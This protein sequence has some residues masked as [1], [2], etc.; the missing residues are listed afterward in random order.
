MAA[1]LVWFWVKR[2]YFAEGRH[3]VE[4]ALRWGST[5][6]DSVSVNLLLGAWNLAYWMGDYASAESAGQKA[7]ALSREA[8]DRWRAAFSL[9][10]L[11][12]NATTRGEYQQATAL[13]DECL[14][15]ARGTGDGWLI[16]H[17]LLVLGV[18]AYALE[19]DVQATTLF[20]E[21]LALGRQV[22][23][24]WL[25][26]IVA[27]SLAEAF[28]RQDNCAQARSLYVEALAIGRELEDRILIS[29]SLEGLAAMTRAQGQ[30]VTAA[31]LYGAAEAQREAIGIPVE[32]AGR[33]AYERGVARPR[34]A[35]GE[36]AFA[37]A[38]ADGRTLTIEHVIA[39]VLEEPGAGL[40]VR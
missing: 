13:A 28:Q 32:A 30:M 15:L 37:A 4:R 31:R 35:L 27:I 18:V 2:G 17:P 25:I 9:F 33:A 16:A 11:G 34:A 21:A 12:L 6:P 5:G 22:G 40:P 39:D 10:A 7:L 23:D 24:R 29:T 1:A 3:L 20:A 26:G 36:A 8:G 14:A 38:W 19:D